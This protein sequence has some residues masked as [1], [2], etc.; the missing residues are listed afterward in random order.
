MYRHLVESIS[1]SRHQ[2]RHQEEPHHSLW[3]RGHLRHGPF[4]SYLSLSP[5]QS[6]I[7]GICELI[8]ATQSEYSQSTR[9]H[10]DGKAPAFLS[11][12]CLRRRR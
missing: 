3:D 11:H 6:L 12:S 9:E 7:Y 2:C 5:T 1:G 10:K 8:D 4:L